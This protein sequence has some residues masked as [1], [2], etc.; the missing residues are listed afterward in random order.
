[1]NKIN[2]IVLVCSLVLLGMLLITINSSAAVLT[3]IDIPVSGAVFNPCN[4]E[5]V[6]FNG[7]EHFVMSVTFNSSGGFQSFT[8]DNVH[9]TATGDQGNSY[10]GNEEDNFTLNGRVGIVQ[11]FPQTFSEISRG[12]APNFELHMLTHV[13]VNA[14]G[15]V[16]VFIST[17]TSSC[18]G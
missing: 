18:R 9:V 6:T 14:N 12:A 15:T 13:T 4:G 5:T 2:G 1:M 7:V 10:E 11:T 8:K 16:T 17:Y 3:N